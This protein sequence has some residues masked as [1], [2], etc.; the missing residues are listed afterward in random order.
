MS[1]WFALAGPEGYAAKYVL[2]VASSSL[3]DKPLAY[4]STVEQLAA[5]MA[6]EMLNSHVLTK[7]VP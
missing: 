2:S 7:Q 4:L 5:W 6:A 3:P 1:S